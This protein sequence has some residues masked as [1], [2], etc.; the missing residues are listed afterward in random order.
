MTDLSIR[1][2]DKTVELPDYTGQYEIKLQRMHGDADFYDDESWFFSGSASGKNKFYK[3]AY[4]LAHLFSKDLRTDD[5]DEINEYI[6]KIAEK[7][8]FRKGKE[9]ADNY[10][11]TISDFLSETLTYE[12][13]GCYRY[14]NAHSLQ[15]FYHLSPSKKIFVEIEI[16]GKYYCEF[17][18]FSN[19][20]F[21]DNESSENSI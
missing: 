11:A 5:T 21:N 13:D 12:C 16:N 15:F 19:I 14:A 6:T 9:S 17:S 3:Q 4:V 10:V 18:Y 20:D 8:K 1:N 7:V 2:T